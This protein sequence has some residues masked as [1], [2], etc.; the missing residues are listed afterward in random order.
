MHEMLNNIHENPV[1]Q[2]VRNWC[3]QR[4]VVKQE[5]VEQ[6]LAKKSEHIKASN[7]SASIQVPEFAKEREEF[8][9]QRINYVSEVSHTFE[10]RTANMLGGGFS[11]LLPPYA[12]Q[13]VDDEAAPG[14]TQS[15][16]AG[17]TASSSGTPDWGGARRRLGRSS[18]MEPQGASRRTGR[19]PYRCASRPNRHAREIDPRVTLKK[20][21]SSHE[22]H[23]RKSGRHY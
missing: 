4:E 20:P 10:A 17:T 14:L 6:E 19:R 2:Q 15:V 5:L 7:L 8:E 21:A 18:A 22:K 9:L 11:C 13:E 3:M 1:F 12:T 23:L 16:H